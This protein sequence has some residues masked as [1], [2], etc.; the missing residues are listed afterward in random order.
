MEKFLFGIESGMQC[1]GCS[2]NNVDLSVIYLMVLDLEVMPY[3]KHINKL[4]YIA[5]FGSP[6][7]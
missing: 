7:D 2:R 1:F 6:A 5:S 4:L 3:R